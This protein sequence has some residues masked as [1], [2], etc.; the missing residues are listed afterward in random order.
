MTSLPWDFRR[1]ATAST[2]NAVSA[3][4]P[5][6]NWLSVTDISDPRLSPNPHASLRACGIRPLPRTLEDARA[7]LG[8]TILRGFAVGVSRRGHK[9][10]R[11]KQLRLLRPDAPRL[12]QLQDR[13]K[14]SQQ[15]AARVWR[16]EDMRERHAP[17]FLDEAENPLHVHLDRRLVHDDLLG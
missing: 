11:A 1:R 17:S 4:S 7:G 15:P 6:E 14:E 8:R 10:D 2:S 3:V 13:E 12:D 9:P 5:R 16:R